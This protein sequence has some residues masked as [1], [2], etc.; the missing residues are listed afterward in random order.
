MRSRVDLNQKKITT[1]LKSVG[2][3]VHDLTNV[4]RG[5]PDILVGFR[6][7]NHLFEIK[8]N[9]TCKLTPHQEEWHAGWKGNAKVVYSIEDVIYYLEL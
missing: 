6:G 9:R 2:A 5:C 3:T 4:G 7:K 1:L 8:Q